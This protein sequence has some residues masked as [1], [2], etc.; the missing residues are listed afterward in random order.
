[1][2]E[3]EH[4]ELFFGTSIDKQFKI[5]SDDKT[6]S[7]TNELLY[8]QQFELFESLCSEKELVFGSCESS[9]IKFRARNTFGSIIGKWL[10][11][12]VVL[13]NKTDKPFKIGRYKVVSD[14][15]TDDKKYRTIKAFDVLHDVINANVAQWYNNLKFPMTLKAFRN[16]FFK[17]LGITEESVS[18]INDEMTVEKTIYSEEISGKLIVNAIC[19]INGVFGHINRNGRFV[20]VSLNAIDED[21]Y[22]MLTLY[23]SNTIYPA[24][25]IERSIDSQSYMKS[26]YKTLS[27]E[28]F[29][30]KKIGKLQLRQEEGDIGF[31]VGSGEN[32]YIVEDNFLLYGKSETELETIANLLYKKIKNIEYI[33]FK[34]ACSGNPTIEVGDALEIEK[35]DG[36]KIKTYLLSRSMKGIQSLIDTMQA[37]GAETYSEKVNSS[38]K[39]IIKL[40]GKTNV[41]ERSI[42]KNALE[43]TELQKD[44][45]ENYSTTE[46]TK[47][48]IEQTSDSIRTEVS[49][50]YT[51]QSS[52]D[53][54]VNN[55]QQ[56]I[57]GAIETFTGSHVPTLTN[58]PVSNWETNE[59]KETHIGDLYVVNSSGG[60]YA[61]FYYRFEKIDSTYQWVLLKDSEVTKALQ[62]AKEANEKAQSVSDD[63]SKNYS[64]TTQM[65][66]AISQ[67]ATEIKSTVSATYET[68][69]DAETTKESLQSQITQNAESITAK[70]AKGDVTAQLNIELGKILLKGNRIAIESDYFTLTEDGKIKAVDGEFSGAITGSSFTA[71]GKIVRTA[72]DYT[73]ADLESLEQ[74]LLGNEA[75]TVEDMEKYDLNADGL[76]SATDLFALNRL[77]NGTVP[78]IEIDTSVEINPLSKNGIIKTAGVSIHANGMFSKKISSELINADSLRVMQDGVGHV[79]GI[80]ATYV[81]DG[82][83]TITKGVIT[84]I[85][86]KSAYS[87]S[88]NWKYKK[89]DDFGTYEVL[90]KAEIASGAFT[91]YG[92]LFYRAVTISGCPVAISELINFTA[93]ANAYYG[94]YFIS[95]REFTENSISFFVMSPNADAAS[96]NVFIRAIVKTSS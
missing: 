86:Q 60:D 81:G 74:K 67:S 77:L 20:Y 34:C 50:T 79:D 85:A 6:V 5:E 19:E 39:E 89:L 10:N 42:S 9:Y 41:L 38:Q 94:G 59:E 44:I 87:T 93:N 16:S 71:I 29:T 83:I 46:E 40:K 48:L 8:Q 17:Y 12:S 84:N 11:V 24:S 69:T 33:P 37:K 54:T 25:V 55:L 75:I 4:G 63:L 61:G 21:L 2:V 73:Q 66:S 7:I 57:D 18:L 82:E 31:I 72:A 52:F 14:V 3:Y 26:N 68:K 90:C 70:V 27:Y 58:Y 43:I 91:A 15:P 32:S 65:N 28:D 53:S 76:L 56:Q 22:P 23:P 1:M 35:A 30:T 88:G 51:T 92:N 80:D 95:L 62:D 47:S 36:E 13:D 45:N 49:K 78:S 64:T 96:L